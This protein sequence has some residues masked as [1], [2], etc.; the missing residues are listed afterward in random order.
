MGLNVIPMFASAPSLK[1]LYDLVQTATLYVGGLRKT[2]GL[3]AARRAVERTS[4]VVYSTIDWDIIKV[5]VYVS[6]LCHLLKGISQQFRKFLNKSRKTFTYKMMDTFIAQF[7]KLVTQILY[8]FN[9]TTCFNN[10][11]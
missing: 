10:F 4:T 5:N 3:K 9:R 8:A 2:S 6:E 11:R 1:M 7:L